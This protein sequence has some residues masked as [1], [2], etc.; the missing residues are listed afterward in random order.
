MT[1]EKFEQGCEII[2][3]YAE[4]IGPV[5]SITFSDCPEIT[6]AE[7]LC[8]PGDWEDRLEC[9]RELIRANIPVKLLLPGY[10]RICI[11]DEE[12]DIADLER[13]IAESR[14][15]IKDIESILQELDEMKE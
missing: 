9:C 15:F 8:F 12:T 10:L 11:T 1:R 3:R 2:K 5:S 6:E 7:S 14:E 13:S 4:K